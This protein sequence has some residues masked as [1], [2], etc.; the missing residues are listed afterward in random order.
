[1][2]EGC[3]TDLPLGDEEAASLRW[4]AHLEH[5]HHPDAVACRLKLSLAAAPCP[6][7]SAVLPWDIVEQVR[8][9]RRK[10]AVV[11]RSRRADGVAAGLTTPADS[12]IWREEIT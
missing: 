7:M 4:L 3:V 10:V 8:R 2:V 1:M 9:Y 12:P 11:T 6:E 5:D